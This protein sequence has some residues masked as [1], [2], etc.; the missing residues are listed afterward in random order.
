MVAG[1]NQ[2]LREAM[3]SRRLEIKYDLESMATTA[4]PPQ[5]LGYAD[6]C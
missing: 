1:W 4:T 2:A 6:G 3:N 5:N